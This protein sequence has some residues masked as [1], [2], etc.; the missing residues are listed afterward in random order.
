[1]R[2]K[3]KYYIQ[4]VKVALIK[5]K[6]FIIIMIILLFISLLIRENNSPFEPVKTAKDIY[7]YHNACVLFG[8]KTCQSC[9]LT[10]KVLLP[11]LKSNKIKIYYFD[12]DDL[13]D[14]KEFDAVLSD[15]HVEQVPVLIKVENGKYSN[16][17]YLIDENN[18]IDSNKVKNTIL[19]WSE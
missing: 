6:N 3:F 19:D 12:T 11:I 18:R 14:Q 9:R 15:F 13:R 10:N 16:S 5:I 1:M 7:S 2:L 8:R 4:K 17:M